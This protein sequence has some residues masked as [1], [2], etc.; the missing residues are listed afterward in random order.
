MAAGGLGVLAVGALAQVQAPGAS[1]SPAAA[2]FL[3]DARWLA[4][5]SR[6]GR[7]LGTAGLAEAGEWIAARFREA[8]L[9][10]GG[11]AG[12]FLHRFEVP[13]GVR[14]GPGTAAAVD[15]RA[16]PA[17]EIFPIGFSAVAEAEGETVVAGFGITAPELGVD[18]YAGVAAKGRVVVVR[19]FAPEGGPFGAEEVASRYGDLRYKAWNAREHGAIGLV[20]VDLP[21]GLQ[22]EDGAES[23]LPPE[24]VPPQLS[25]ESGGGDAG[26]PAVVLSRAS[27][28]A[29]FD[30]GHRVRLAVDLVRRS[31]FT[32]NVVGVLRAG[33]AEGHA[34]PMAPM[35][36]MGPVVL[37][38]HYDHLGM[39]GPGSLA[40]LAREPHNG[41]DD[42]AS[43]VAALL[44]A[45]RRLAARRAELRR[46]VV[47]V[48][49]SGEESGLFGSTSLVRQPP[50]GL[51]LDS[52]LAMINLDMVGRLRDKL[53]V[54]AGE[55]ALEWPGLVRPACRRAGLECTLS[56]EGYGPSD[57]T[58]F[59]A[60]GLPVLHL[61]TGFHADYHRPTDDVD[62][63]DP[64][65]GAK[66]A[67]LAADLAAELAG[68][69][70]RLTYHSAPVPVRLAGDLRSY[71][72][73]LGTLVDTPPDGRPG[74]LIA[75]L[76]P[77][78]AAERAGL[79]R[80]DRLV[81]LAGSAV[82]DTAALTS[83]MRKVRPGAKAPAVVERAGARL[84][85]EVIFGGAG[86]S[87]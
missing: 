78:G 5:D 25:I 66:I 11:D 62:R 46:D 18:D 47:F 21:A 64:E 86:R 41:A 24:A 50:A 3:A 68:R 22:A 70:G 59:Y 74:V 84:T 85:V 83:L 44:E 29:L 75:E 39:G 33:A 19:R 27:G 77:G 65:G 80:G 49:F 2:R 16:V 9:E 1:L 57:H 52:A 87:R 42:N 45:A 30:G 81:E 7:G 6:Q 48:A 35:A 40:P 36:S 43:G 31:L 26:I 14:V 51:R 60:A 72:A 55:T 38:A 76:Q 61:F 28:A 12:G 8:G 63:L 13:V 37:G 17:G 69:P 54:L 20:I 56:G 79:R 15:G 58:P 10:P 32:A 53:S 73:S 82:R 67:G 4:D 23:V 34:S 71:G